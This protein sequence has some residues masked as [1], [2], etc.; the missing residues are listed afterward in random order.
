[1][2]TPT[3]ADA[4]ALAAEMHR[5]AVDKAG[6]PYILHPLRVMLAM[7]TDEARRVAVLHDVIEDSKGRVTPDDLRRLG[8]PDA[9]VEALV[10]LTKRPEEYDEYEAFIE[11][12]RA[13]DLAATVKRADLEDN[14]DVRR[15]SDFGV[16]DAE[17]VAKYLR[18]WRRLGRES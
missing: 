12:V 1:M 3:V 10:A 2:N 4:V 11:R 17:R 9:E 7:T 6:A 5:D 15:L 18:A 16:A 8:Y 13:N 14:M